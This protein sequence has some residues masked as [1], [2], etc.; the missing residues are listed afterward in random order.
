MLVLHCRWGHTDDHV[1]VGAVTV[2]AVGPNPLGGGVI[3]VGGVARTVRRGDIVRL[4]GGVRM[5][6]QRFC[7][8]GVQFGIDAPQDVRIMGREKLLRMVRCDEEADT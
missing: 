2:C 4:D 8:G 3:T 5:F 1:H 6:V 7:R